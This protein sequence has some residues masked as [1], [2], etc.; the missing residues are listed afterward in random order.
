M[1]KMI[2][3]QEVREQWPLCMKMVLA[4]EEL[5]IANEGV[6]VAKLS[7]VCD[8]LSSRVPGTAK[9]LGCVAAD[10]NTPLPPELLTDLSHEIAA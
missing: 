8:S 1:T 4:G 6:P 2:S 9:G 3:E 10:F 5:V 7:P